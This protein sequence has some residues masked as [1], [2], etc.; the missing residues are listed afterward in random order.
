[1]TNLNLNDKRVRRRCLTT[2]EW[3]TDSI[4]LDFKNIHSSTIRKHIGNSDVGRYLQTLLLTKTNPNYIVGKVSQQY[5]INEANFN[6]LCDQLG[7]EE[8]QLQHQGVE[9]RF[10]Q[11]QDAVVSGQF[12][13]KES[14]DR[15]HNSLQHIP[16][17]LKSQYWAE[18]GYLYDYDIEACAPTLLLQA[19]Q[20]VNP[21]QR[22][23][24]KIE[25]YL[26]NK[27]QVRNDLS[28]KYNLTSKQ[29]KELLNGLFQGGVMNYWPTNRLFNTVNQNHYIMSQLKQDQFLLE[30]IKDIKQMWKSLRSEITCERITGIHKAEFY[31]KLEREV[32]TPVWTYLKKKGVRCFREHDG[33]RSDTFIIPE[34]LSH[35][36]QTKTTYQV[37]FK[38]TKMA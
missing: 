33:F 7:V 16:K 34:D 28:I 26:N 32:M 18:R 22:P 29:V 6:W 1:M 10:E 4:G 11:Q 8:P 27:D 24:T 2:I 30:L 3:L 23:L 20:K 9:R 25:F 31:R 21:K 19:S 15:W 37:K 5:R 13:Y 14:G 38:W 12:D 17:D 35:L 36:V